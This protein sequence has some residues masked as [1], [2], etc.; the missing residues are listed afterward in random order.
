[1][2]WCKHPPT[3]RQPVQESAILREEVAAVQ[4]QQRRA[5]PGDRDFERN[6]TDSDALHAPPSG[7]PARHYRDQFV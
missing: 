2:A 4:K 7:P 6:L 3:T 5:A 1:V